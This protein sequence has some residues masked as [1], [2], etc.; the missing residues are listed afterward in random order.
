MCFIERKFDIF[1]KIKHFILQIFLKQNRNK[2]FRKKYL[3]HRAILILF[4]SVK[5][6]LLKFTVSTK[7]NTISMKKKSVNTSQKKNEEKNPFLQGK[8]ISFLRSAFCI[9]Y[10]LCR[11]FY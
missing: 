5:V 4:V 2:L 7:Y 11:T 10:T 3:S 9:F 1:K 8:Y 6:I